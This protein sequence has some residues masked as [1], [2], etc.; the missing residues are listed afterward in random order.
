MNPNAIPFIPQVQVQTLFTYPFF[1]Q[2]LER[3]IFTH[4]RITDASVN[5]LQILMVSPP[6]KPQ[7]KATTVFLGNYKGI[8]L[9]Y[10]ADR[11]DAPRTGA[12]V[13]VSA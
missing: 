4:H 10:E 7:A 1:Q 9:L 12:F 6:I 2:R 8:P 11:W 5:D 13:K 3:Y